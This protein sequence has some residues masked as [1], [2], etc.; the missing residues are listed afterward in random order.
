MYIPFKVQEARDKEIEAR[1]ERVEPRIMAMLD[2]PPNDYRRRKMVGILDEIH[3]LGS[4]AVGRRHGI[5]KFLRMFRDMLVTPAGELTEGV[6][7]YE[8][9][10][11]CK[12]LDER[13]LCGSAPDVLWDL[14]HLSN[15]PEYYTAQALRVG[16]GRYVGQIKYLL[17]EM[18]AGRMSCVRIDIERFERDMNWKSLPAGLPESPRCTQTLQAQGLTVSTKFS[19]LIEMWD[20]TRFVEMSQCDVCEVSMRRSPEE[21]WR[22]IRNVFYTDIPTREISTDM[23][24]MIEWAGDD[25]N[26]WRVAWWRALDAYDLE[27]MLIEARKRDQGRW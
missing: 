22:R 23:M 24:S 11:A 27:P 17:R 21:G 12:E 2:G 14:G 26:S 9:N 1:V 10:A 13:V 25:Y 4:T 5:D 15:D 3:L 18:R 16:G 7:R 19:S 20:D 6:E 8:V